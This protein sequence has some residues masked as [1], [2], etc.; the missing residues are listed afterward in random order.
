MFMKKQKAEKNK[1]LSIFSLCRAAYIVLLLS[2]AIISLYFS[3]RGNEKIIDAVCRGFV[4]PYQRIVG[5]VCSYVPFS[6]AELIYAALVIWSVCYIVRAVYRI[7]TRESKLL[8]LYKTIITLLAASCGF[9]AGFC[10]LWGVYYTSAGFIEDSGMETREYSVD[11]LSSVT[12]Y[13]AEL[14]NE[15]GDKVQR[16]SD[17]GFDVPL[18]EIFD[19][20]PGLYQNVSE[21]FS[22]LKWPEMRA[23]PFFTSKL[24]SL[25]N[26][27]G[28]FFPF[29]AE[30]NINIDSPSCLIPSTIAHEL[31]HQ[32]GVASED[33]A[34]FVGILASM[35]SGNETYIYSASL[36]A[37][38]HL[39]NALY[40]ADN[41]AWSDVFHSL[42][43]NVRS[44]LK[45]NNEYW[46]R[47]ETKISDAS[48]AV[49]TGFLESY[50]EERGLKSYGAC[51]DLLISYYL[52][53]TESIK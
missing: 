7:I 21:Q 45:S 6:V 51:I 40:K 15:Y 28:F 18:D 53:E 50:G 2:A 43:A 48:D 5:T 16:N 44:D 27:T 20:A 23:K 29:T 10:L 35:E 42:S 38:I 46:D 9:Y 19:A 11:E 30:A 36:L 34:N 31:A 17:G 12:Q 41:N 39:G 3:L 49:Y 32:R 4:R 47:F 24:L 26:F 13:F 8:C 33:E 14:A 22:S 1:I 52:K 37:Y 25:I